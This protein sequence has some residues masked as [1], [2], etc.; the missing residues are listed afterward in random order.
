MKSVVTNEF[1]RADALARLMSSMLQ[2][3]LP[4]VTLFF[5]CQQI[6][7]TYAERFSRICI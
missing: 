7:E 1:S 4:G 5:S 6:T 3:D 2:G